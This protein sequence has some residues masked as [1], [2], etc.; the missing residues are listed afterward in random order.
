MA[1]SIKEISKEKKKRQSLDFKSLLEK[2]ISIGNGGFNNKKKEGFYSE[3]GVLLNAGI[4][5]KDSLSLLL[6]EVKKPKDK[7][8]FN[9]MVTQ[10]VQGSNF[11]DCIRDIKGFSEYEFYSLKIG[12]ETGTLHKVTVELGLFFRRKNEQRKNLMNAISYPIVVLITALLSVFFMLKFVVPMFA[13]IFKQNGVELPVLTKIIIKL[14]LLMEQYFWIFLIITLGIFILFKSVQKKELYKKISSTFILKIPFVG[15]L[16]RKMYLAQFTQAVAL[17]TS[18]NIPLLNSLQLTLKM[19]DFYPL[20]FALKNVE[21]SV[22]EGKVLSDSLRPY[23]IFDGKMVSLIKVAEETNQ[24]DY[25]FSRLTIQY[26]EE[27]QYK[28]KMLSTIIEP[29]III[30]LGS[31]VALILVAMYL[32]MFKLSTVLG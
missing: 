8:M 30:V 18:A 7:E 22:L 21:K 13:D 2:D 20:K 19:I 3:L 27:V 16:I 11:S 29:I 12:E 24:N 4:N 23:K 1:F 26:N 5:L 9:Q 6:D 14:S 25:I 28:S 31:L 32:P 10:I 15:E 17:L